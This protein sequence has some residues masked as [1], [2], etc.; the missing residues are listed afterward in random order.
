MIA[1]EV[2]A[3]RLAKHATT[4]PCAGISPALR[5]VRSARRYASRARGLRRDHVRRWEPAVRGRCARRERSG[6]VRGGAAWRRSTE[7]AVVRASARLW[8]LRGVA[9]QELVAVLGA[10]HARGCQARAR[11]IAD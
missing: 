1:E 2:A 5:T 6:H 4:P 8:K 7:G 11:E 10:N 3:N 9:G